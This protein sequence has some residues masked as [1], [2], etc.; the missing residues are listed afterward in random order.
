MVSSVVWYQREGA[1]G[2][3]A[4][5][6]VRQEVISSPDGSLPMLIERF[7]DQAERQP[8]NPKVWLSLFPLYR[9]SGQFEKA[10]AALERLI[11]LEGRQVNLLAQLAQMKFLIA[12]RTLT[13]D[14]QALVDEVLSR[15]PRQP[16]VLSMLGI[17]AFDH[18][19]YEEAIDYWRRAIAG[20]NDPGAADALR[21]GIATAQQ[22][23]GIAPEA[24]KAPGGGPSLIVN[25]SLADHLRSRASQ[26]DTVFVVAR[27]VEG[28]L[29]PS[30]RARH[31]GRSTIRGDARR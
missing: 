24:S 4:L 1:E 26:S 13:D 22:R 29:P 15:D 16:T 19:R 10:S 17:E 25:V 14:V 18:G 27:D 31:G 5:F 30:R 28:K 12:N 9:D 2:D 8:E 21:D 11:S 20:F 23:L 3:L 7:E 6:A